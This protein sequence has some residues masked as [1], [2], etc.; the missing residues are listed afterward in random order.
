MLQQL[1]PHSPRGDS[2]ECSCNA[3]T[4]LEILKNNE[5]FRESLR[6]SV[7]KDG[8]T[9]APGL[10]VSSIFNKSYWQS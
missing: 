5:N 6:G 1:N 7:G 3:T 2:G 9:G 10:T 4:I 8:N